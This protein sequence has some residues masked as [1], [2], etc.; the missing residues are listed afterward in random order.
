M[1]LTIVMNYTL[2][3]SLAMATSPSDKLVQ[4][5]EVGT[6]EVVDPAK[7]THEEDEARTEE[8]EV[9]TEEEEDEPKEEAIESLLESTRNLNI[10]DEETNQGAENQNRQEDPITTH[11]SDQTMD[12][13]STSLASDQNRPLDSDPNTSPISLSVQ[14]QGT[15]NQNPQEQ[16]MV[17]PKLYD[18]QEPL[19]D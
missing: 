12:R 5:E 7:I 15:E 4:E 6:D 16:S 13:G 2:L 19:S 9:R 10:E 18:H 14:D 8:E 3:S 1:C 11:R 17:H